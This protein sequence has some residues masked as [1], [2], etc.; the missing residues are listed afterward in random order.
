MKI[1]KNNN[2]MNK[3]MDATGASRLDV[4][5]NI[6]KDLSS[7]EAVEMRLSMLIDYPDHTYSAYDDENLQALADS[8]K[9]SGL[10]NPITV[11]HKKQE[12]IILAGHNRKR[13]CELA[14]LTHATCILKEN[15]TD[16]EA[17][18]IV[19]TSNL[20]QRGFESLSFYDKCRSIAQV[21]KATKEIYENN[22]EKYG[23][24]NVKGF[25]LKEEVSQYFNIKARQVATYTKIY[26]TFKK[27]WYEMIPEVI[28]IKTA[29]QLCQLDKSNYKKV[30]DELY[31]RFKAGEK[32][33]IN[34]V[35]AKELRTLE[36]DGAD[37][38]EL[39][40][41]ID[42]KNIPKAKKSITINFY[43]DEY[44]SLYDDIQKLDPEVINSI[45]MKA[46]I[47]YMKTEKNDD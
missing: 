24:E 6:T 11:W 8:I 9:L 32:I 30:L 40:D 27:D 14:G 38:S 34:K 45:I 44:S 2:M 5:K 29:E 42:S 26:E 10:I 33:K 37:S 17:S 4:L 46:L 28:N 21:R 35:K 23:L 20:D 39:V 31:R 41:A 47:K 16:A 36:S 1:S 12:Y 13:A 15:L 25:D 18:L 22:K 43:T 19:N 7:G 3:I